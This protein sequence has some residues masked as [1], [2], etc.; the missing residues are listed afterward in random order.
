MI[1]RPVDRRTD[2]SAKAYLLAEA[3]IADEPDA[4]GRRLHFHSF[5]K[6]FNTQM[7]R[8]NLPEAIIMQCLRVTDRK[9]IDRT[10][11]DTDALKPVE[12]CV[13]PWSPS[14]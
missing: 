6:T 2:A 14:R 4:H 1:T 10:Y 9:L 3:G 12:M 11:L 8:W 7:Q 5:R 13:V